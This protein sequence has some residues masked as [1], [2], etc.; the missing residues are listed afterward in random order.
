MKALLAEF[1]GT[2]FLMVT[3][4]VSVI[5]ELPYPPVIIGVILTG[6][7]YITG[8]VS[9]AHLNPAITIGFLVRRKFPLSSVLPYILVQLVGSL[10][11]VWLVCGL[12]G[13]EPSESPQSMPMPLS[14]WG[15]VIGTFLLASVIWSVA[16]LERTKGN[17][18]YGAAIGGIVMV[19]ALLFGSWS[20]AHFNPATVLTAILGGLT[21]LA[22][23]LFLLSVICGTA[24]VSALL[25]N[26]LEEKLEA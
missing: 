24:I 26:L 7:V 18:Y 20:G 14:F 22:D 13:I 10:L 12:L 3:I 21:P 1:L 5:L 11:A 16:T 6:I 15:E 17:N 8:P 9:G 23:A 19:G 2:F 25:F 4:L